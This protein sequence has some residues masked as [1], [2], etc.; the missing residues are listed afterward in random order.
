MSDYETKK[1]IDGKNIALVLMT[2]GGVGGYLWLDHKL[3]LEK[4]VTTDLTNSL[5]QLAATQPVSLPRPAADGGV[6][7]LPKDVVLPA[8]SPG[9]PSSSATPRRNG[10]SMARLP[11]I[12]LAPRTY[13]EVFAHYGR[14]LPVA[15]LRALALHESDLRPRLADGPAWGLMQIIEVVREDFNRRERKN[16]T[17]ADLLDPAVSV[18]IAASSLAL[19]ARSYATNHP[20]VPN[21]QPNWRNPQFVA[22]LTLGWNAGWSERGG[23]GRVASFLSQRGAEVTVNSVFDAAR[24]AGASLHLANQSKLAFAKQVTRQ[25]FAEL[26]DEERVIEIE[27]TPQRPTNDRPAVVVEAPIESPAQPAHSGFHASMPAYIPMSSYGVPDNGPGFVPSHAH[28]EYAPAPPSVASVGMSPANVGPLSEMAHP[29]EM[30]PSMDAAQ[31]ME[32]AQQMEMAI[33][34]NPSGGSGP[35]DPYEEGGPELHGYPDD[36][37]AYSYAAEGAPHA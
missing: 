11:R 1:G 17:R 26:A 4:K 14:D 30:T 5:M 10:T 20:D 7:V 31:P 15:Y 22:L 23:V 33:M 19:I 6:E 29:M 21:L 8:L 3:R 12:E 36:P 27:D 28:P 25:Y 2:L 24:A 35:I 13:D 16:F 37:Y 32:V 34:S 18:T 9:A